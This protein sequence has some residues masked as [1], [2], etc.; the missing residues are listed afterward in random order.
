MITRVKKIY[1]LGGK[2]MK[3]TSFLLS[4]VTIS[5]GLCTFSQQ[6]S[7]QSTHVP[8]ETQLSDTVETTTW[9]ADAVY[10]GGDIVVHNGLKYMAKAFSNNVMPGT[11]IYVWTLLTIVPET[12]DWS[13]TKAYNGGDVVVYNGLE[14]MAQ[15]FTT[16]QQPGEFPVWKLLTPVPETNEWNAEKTYNGG[17]IVVYKG[18]EYMGKSFS[19]NVQ[20]GTSSYQWVLLTSTP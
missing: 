14:Y 17:D 15:Y 8:S 13:A 6:S 16:G 11:N 7:A 9:K 1:L 12:N 10:M 3:K 18:L 2:K 20:P 4:M 19:R 5:A